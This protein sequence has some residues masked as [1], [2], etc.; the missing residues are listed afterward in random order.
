MF[1]LLDSS[2]QNNSLITAIADIF[3]STEPLIIKNYQL[4]PYN[5]KFQSP[6]KTAS[7]TFFFRQGL[8]LKLL[9]NDSFFSIGECAPMVEIG[10]ESLAQAQYFLDKQ[11]PV[12]I[13]KPI[14]LNMLTSDM[15]QFP[16][17]RFAL[18]TALLSLLAQQ[19]KKNIAHL[20]SANKI[21]PEYSHKIKI[22]A[23]I[24]ELNSNTITKAKQAEKRG[25][26]CLKIKVGRN[27][28]DHEARMLEHLFHQL[29][30]ST[31]IRLDANKSWTLKESQ[32]FLNF[33][34]AYKH[35][36]DSIEE[37]LK[38]FA[39]N[40]YQELQNSTKI[41]L[42]LDESFSINSHE[43]LNNTNQSSSFKQYPVKQLVL[44]PM[45][46]GGVIST[47]HL[48]RQAQR[49]NINT[50]ITSSIETAHG[51]WP[52][53]YLCAAINNNQFHGLATASWLEDTLIEPPE[54]IN[55]SITL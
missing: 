36:I 8:L 1:T 9:I 44:K 42:A 5:V 33:L 26:K 17:C 14:S 32:W 34:Q 31:L 12:I 48:A 50:V 20:L 2:L 18:E 23:M 10:T 40:I 37:P 30:A 15:D 45:A 43:L 4:I 54:I 19:K 55:G 35:Q 53:S 27:T 11:L 6:W 16:A 7:S 3:E 52:I 47:L 22:N 46:Q 28:I 24:G 25:F 41:N 49:A 51:L 13:G 21:N 38:K 29:S 39:R